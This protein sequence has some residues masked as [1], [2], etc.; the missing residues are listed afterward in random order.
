MHRLS[1][2]LSVLALTSA[3]LAVCVTYFSFPPMGYEGMI[4]LSSVAVVLALGS[5]LLSLALAA[6]ILVTKKPP[7]PLK[8]AAI[9]IVS[10][11]IALGYI[12]TM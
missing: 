7:K 8:P 11:A 5:G 10:I 4:F 6:I 1:N 2:F 9:S 12:W 3:T